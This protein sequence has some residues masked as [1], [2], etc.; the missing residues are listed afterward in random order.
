[1]LPVDDPQW[2]SARSAA[3][4]PA[5]PGRGQAAAAS[6]EPG[7]AAA[8]GLRGPALDRLRDPGASGQLG[9]EPADRAAA[10][11]GQ[12]SPGVPAWLGQQDLLHASCGI[13]PLPPES[14]E[15]LL[16]ALL[17]DDRE[18]QPL[19]ELL[20]ERTE[21]N[22]FFLEESVRTLVETKVL[23]GERGAYRLAK[24]VESIQ[25]PAT[26]QAV[27]AARI[28][29]LPPEDKRLLQSA[30]VIGKDVPFALLQAIAELS[31]EELRRGLAHLQA[32]EFLY[33]TQSVPRPR[34]HLQARAHPRGRLREPA[35]G[36]AAR[37]S[38]ADRGSDR[39][40]LSGPPGRA[41]RAA[42]PPR[43]SGRAVGEGGRLPS[44]GR[45]QSGRPLGESR[46]GSVLRAG[47]GALKHLPESRQTIEQAINI[48]VDFGPALISTKGFPATEVE[49]NYT[50]ARVAVR[51]VRGDASNFSRVVGT[52][53]DARYSRGAEGGAGV[54]QSSFLTLAQRAKTQRYSLKPTTNFGPTCLLSAS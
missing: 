54:W 36:A 27:L 13:D 48:R 45:R 1:M 5:H 37:A 21:G 40:A 18:L 44:S 38:R 52:G 41:G 47:A 30:A 2:Q 29:R 50:R 53:K 26:V 39:G 33:E 32:A 10:A 17:G 3:A 43:V 11:A 7:P 20:I 34:I 14:A 12:L 15:E 8:A 19:K 51:A 25:V 24:P 46:G 9:G 22:P 42:R 49:E 35:P 23:A 16:Q 4:P 28:D 31:E 6:R